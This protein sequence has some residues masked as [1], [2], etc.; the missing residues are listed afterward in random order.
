MW[1][2]YDVTPWVTADGTYTFA[3]VADSNDGVTFSSREGATPPQLVVTLGTGALLSSAFVPALVDTPVPTATPSPILEISTP[4]S[5]GAGTPEV[6]PSLLTYSIRPDGANGVDTYLQNTTAASNLGNDVAIG[7]GENNNATSQIARALIKFDLSAIPS[8]ATIVSATLSLWTASDL[9]DNDR[10]LHVHRLKVPFDE[11]QATWTQSAAGM[12]W[13]TE[14]A[15]GA[16]DRESIQIGSIQIAADEAIGTQKQIFLSP[17]MIQEL[18]NGSFINN[19]FVILVDGESNDRFNYEA[20]D[21][22]NVSNR[23]MLVI[24]YTLP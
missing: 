4:T 18:V 17:A 11:S 13:Q 8:N 21:S 3:L 2:E 20:S 24:E 12:D 16:E 23:P 19:G 14:G 15:S 5:M 10:I 22:S 6:S 7:I 1:V 9:S